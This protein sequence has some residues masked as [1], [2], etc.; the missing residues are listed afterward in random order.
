MCMKKEDFLNLLSNCIEEGNISFETEE[1]GFNERSTILYL[2]IKNNG[3][4]ETHQI[5]TIY[6]KK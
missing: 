5:A 3:E 2:N 6:H 4:R 1:Y